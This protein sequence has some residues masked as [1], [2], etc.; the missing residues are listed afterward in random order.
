MQAALP[1]TFGGDYESVIQ[2]SLSREMG[3]AKLVVSFG[4]NPSETR[5]SG[6]GETY[7]Y[8][9]WL[10]RKNVKTILID[11]RY[12]DSALGKEDEW[13][14]IRPGTDAALVE[15]I[16]YVLIT[17]HMVAENFLEKYC[18]GYDEKTLPASA[19]RNGHYKA[20]ILGQ[21]ADGIV[22]TPEW[23]ARIT[24]I[25]AHRIVKLAREIGQTSPVFFTQ[26]WGI[27]R[28]ANG[29]QAC[30]A[31]C[32]LPLLTGN[33]GLPG[34]NMGDQPGNYGGF[35]IPGLPEFTNNV[36]ESIS[37]FMWTDAIA[38]GKEMTARHDGVRGGDSLKQ[39]I[40]FMWNYASG[41]L[42]NQ[43]SD[44]NKTHEILQD[45]SLCEFI[46][47]IDNHM[48]SS[49]R[50]ADIL[51]PDVTNFENTDIISSGYAAGEMGGA[52]FI[53]QAIEPLGE[54]KSAY[55]ICTE[56]ADYLGMREKYTEGKT[57]EQWVEWIYAQMKAKDA[58]LP[59]T[60]AQARQIGMI[61]RHAPPGVG[62]AYEAFRKDP[63]A[64]PVPTPSGKFEIYSQALAEFATTVDLP[65][66]DVITPLPQYVATWEGAEDYET[67]KTYPLQLHGFH[68][69]GRTHSTY[70]NLDVLR[71][72]VD[73]AVW[74]NPIDANPRG[75]KDGD[76]VHISS[77]R[78]TIE[79]LA[80]VT[81]RVM[82][83]VV[84]LGQGAW[85]Q[86]NEKGID[87]GGCIN[88]LTSQRPSPLAKG[89]PQHTNLVE[90]VK[91]A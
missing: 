28:Q 67:K 24:G 71:Q 68:T 12:T 52:L 27:Q 20:H 23:A 76:K 89:N 73:D 38:R 50:Y 40:K 60:L 39:P 70:H 80:K 87:T 13:I 46:L 45:E 16:A 26:G 35:S 1:Y 5:M 47:V 53:S 82:P 32:M 74:I 6:G 25:P 79:V 36:K 61:K 88:T 55:Q 90:I 43:H 11:P 62:I 63:Q 77:K 83:G 72:A 51:L 85:Y 21:G 29:E 78:G 34:T 54:A 15:A 64:N 41:V 14:P 8:S 37:M 3:N 65:E 84:S 9:E 2:K 48:T 44:S 58:T 75:I 57:H 7:L 31:I 91:V 59:D 22:K 19:P 81:P 49:A 42:I 30:R 86:P 33:I 10:R 17:E 18:V 69:K 4:Y 66:G 56:I